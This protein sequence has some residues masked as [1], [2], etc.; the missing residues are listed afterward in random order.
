MLWNLVKR[1][2]PSQDGR[3]GLLPLGGNFWGKGVS[4]YIPA[5]RLLNKMVAAFAVH[6]HGKHPDFQVKATLFSS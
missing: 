3:W 4:L 5:M 6:L 1:K 2:E